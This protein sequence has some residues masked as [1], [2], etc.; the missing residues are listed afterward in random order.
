MTASPPP[1]DL[2]TLTIDGREVKVPKGTNLVEAAKTVG[3]EIPIFCYHP[4]LKSVGACR[5]CLV[6]IEKMP[7]LQTAC[8]SPVAEGMIV[9]TANQNVVAAQNGVLEYLLMNHPLDCPI[10]DKGG[11]CPLQDNTFKFGLGVSRF[12]EKKRL[13]DKAFVLSDRIVLDRERC[14]MCYRC[15]RFQAE[16]AGDEALTAI[17]RGGESEIGV[18]EGETFDS[19]FSGNT[20]DLCPVG[21][22]TSRQYRFKARPWDLQRTTSICSGCA[23]GCNVEIHA[24]DGTILRMWGVDNREVND[25]WLCDYGRFDTLPPGPEARVRQPL[26]RQGGTLQP[27]TWE[28]A[29]ARAAEVLRS[30]RTGLIA[31]P[32]ITSEAIWLFADALR[33]TLPNATAGFWPRAAGAWPLEGKIAD[34]PSCKTVILAGIDP[35]TELP[36][37]ALWLRKAVVNGGT[38]VAIGP[39]NGLF[40]DTGHWLRVPAGEEPALVE[41][42]LAAREKA[43]Q[44]GSGRIRPSAAI[45]GRQARAGRTP[46]DTAIAAAAAALGTGPVALLVGTRLADDPKARAVLQ[47]LAETLGATGEGGMVGC[48]PIP[49]NG[50][51]ALDL[52]G[53][54]VAADGG[55]DSASARA[56]AGDFDAV[57]LFGRETWPS[58]GRARKVLITTGPFEADELVDV[59]LPMAHPYEQ[60]GLLTNLE[61]RVQLL[62]GGGLAPHGVLT[63]WL[64]VADLATHL[65]GS[66]PRELRAIRETLSAAH[67]RYK[68]PEGRAGRRGA[69]YLHVG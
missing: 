68:I 57:L 69:L 47:R 19:P 11:E 29:Y 60:A 56:M 54:I 38:L 2:V 36:V 23:V 50:R 7:R 33:A 13:K 4:K 41:R 6:E 52:A 66:P 53:D 31:S 12:T 34:L 39:E 67:P 32:G 63:D 8:T 46:D 17:D 65:G 10:C 14:I 35:W 3:I 37:L 64:V 20:I 58:T 49:A 16:I 62:Q 27:A 59:V 24:R 55:S 18:L 26:V 51:A 15:T 61:G 22:L 9:R 43:G 40:R 28:A 21:A 30:G 5:M 1:A 42:L 45:T 25:S 44:E 48:P